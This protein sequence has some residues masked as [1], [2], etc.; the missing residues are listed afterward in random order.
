M[1]G[2]TKG[3]DIEQHTNGSLFR[4]MSGAAV[5]GLSSLDASEEP[6]ELGRGKKEAQTS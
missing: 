3:L 2:D 6:E 1:S 4:P 5:E